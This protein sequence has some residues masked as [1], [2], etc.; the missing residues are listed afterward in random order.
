[1][2]DEG[3]EQSWREAL[4]RVSTVLLTA[5]PTREALSPAATTLYRLLA[6]VAHE[7]V[8]HDGGAR[9]LPTGKA[10]GPADAARC[11]SDPIRTAMFLRGVAAAFDELTEHLPGGALEVVYAGTGPLAPLV[12]P[13]L[14][15]ERWPS[16]RVTF[17]DINDASVAA[18]RRIVG[19]F[20]DSERHRF[21]VADAASYQHRR[22]IH[23]VVSETMQRALSVEPQVAL[24]VNL[25]AQL[26]P[27][28]VMVP[29]CVR[30]DLCEASP[31]GAREIG[32]ILEVSQKAI[33]QRRIGA[34]RRLTMPRVTSNVFYRTSIQTYRQ[35][36]I[37]FGES[38]LTLP[39]YVWDLN[40]IAEGEVITFWY[41]VGQ[42]P[43]IR[44]ER[45]APGAR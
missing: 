36:S 34:R 15:L 22:P 37:P 4:R 24:A 27:A 14:A 21:V 42:R 7:L 19:L 44:H 1:M 40:E 25:V 3:A 32:S 23:L 11:T 16:A 5:E 39:D 8:Q 45:Q 43:G 41:E 12:V 18:V 31:A 2:K 30:I 35:L 6:S 26:H 33:R 38:G 29:E 17:I 10:I 9:I 28:G 13:L 20:G